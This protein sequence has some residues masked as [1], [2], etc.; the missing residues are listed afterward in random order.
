MGV[1]GGGRISHGSVIHLGRSR[2]SPLVPSSPSM[3]AEQPGNGWKK[4]RPRSQKEIIPEDES[5]SEGE[6]LE[7]FTIPNFQEPELITPD[8]FPGLIRELEESTAA[9]NIDNDE[10]VIIYD[11]AK[12]ALIKHK[13]SAR[14]AAL[15]TLQRYSSRD[16]EQDCSLQRVCQ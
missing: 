9:R 7:H 8:N 6:E 3:R 5:M 1:E 15:R 4:Q 14:G 16:G 10:D 11:D 13:S 2:F 12:G